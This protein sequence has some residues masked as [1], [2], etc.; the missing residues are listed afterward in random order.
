MREHFVLCT[1]VYANDDL[2]D[3]LVPKVTGSFCRW[4]RYAA[5]W[6][7]CFLHQSDIQ[8]KQ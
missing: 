8:R 7:W 4:P 3:D 1:L 2:N 6:I 5:A